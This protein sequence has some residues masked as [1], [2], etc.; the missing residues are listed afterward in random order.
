MPAEGGSLVPLSR[1]MGT[2]SSL[3]MFHRLRDPRSHPEHQG[4]RSGDTESPLLAARQSWKDPDLA[5]PFTD[6]EAEAREARGL[7]QAKYWAGWR[8]D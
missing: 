4:E 8:Q 3:C 5:P 6:G 2:L 7:H 1:D